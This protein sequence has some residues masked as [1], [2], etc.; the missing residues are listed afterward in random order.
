[1]E[2]FHI[3]RNFYASV[4]LQKITDVVTLQAFMVKLT[5]KA[6]KIFG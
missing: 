3:L 5:I 4:K 6:Y 1:M 2:I